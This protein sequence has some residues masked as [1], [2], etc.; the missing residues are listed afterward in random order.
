[1]IHSTAIV[2]TK[3]EIAEGVEIGAYSV[4]EDDVVIGPGCWLGSHVVVRGPTRIGAGNRIHQFASI[5][6]APQDK[7]YA[8]EPTRLEIGEGNTIRE[9]VT[10]NRGTVQDEGV[11][12]VG[13][14][15]WI[16]A[17]VHIAHDCMVGNNTVL[18]NNATLAGHCHLGDHAIMGGFSGVHQFCKIGPYCMLGMFSAVNRDIPAFC[19]VSGNPA[20]PRGVNSE[21]LRRHGFAPEQIRNVRRAYR[22]VYREG[23][24]LEDA[25]A[26]LESRE[27][28][29]PEIA[30]MVASLRAATRGIVR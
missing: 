23:L 3:A 14:G 15:N 25:I 5:G 29:E 20:T 30:P 1:M 4:V 8:G 18:A 11:T 9:F 10:I 16:M 27:A 19:L 17:Y 12:R 24:K 7:K 13:D 2:S 22:T 21:G 6:D 28:D 26:T